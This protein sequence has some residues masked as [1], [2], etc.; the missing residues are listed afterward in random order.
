M[1]KS[2]TTQETAEPTD[3]AFKLAQLRQYQAL[4]LSAKI[5]LTE[6]RVREW[7]DAND[8]LVYVAFSGGKD[9]TVLL[10][11]V[12]SI[13]PD[14]PAVFADTG[15]ELNSILEFVK[16]YSD[17]V[18][19]VKPKM[20][21][22]EVVKKY[23]YPVVNKEQAQR[24]YEARTTKSKELLDIRLNGY[25]SGSGKIS[26]KWRF[27]IDAPFNVTSKCCK[28]LKCSPSN[29]YGKETGR[30]EM[31][32]VMAGESRLR[33]QT[34]IKHGCNAFD[35][36]SPAGRPMMF[37]GEQDVL[38]YL[39][40]NSIPFA[41]CYGLIEAQADGSLKCSGEQ[42]TGCKFCLFGAHKDAENRIQRLA[43]IEPESYRHAMEDLHYDKVMD[44]LGIEW[45]PLSDLDEQRELD[46]EG[47]E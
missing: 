28:I 16:T 2:T 25:P 47:G 5:R 29:I 17:K 34:Y 45:R 15:N 12:W 11:I 27:V 40:N 21:F 24:I 36:K 43:R 10:D 42:R 19:W 41:E 35:L 38:S 6:M 39:V 31:T 26:N 22:E 20:S 44:F 23:G 14:V 33:M 9:S 1:K 18:I 8:G 46:F 3:N 37:W 32:A 7:Y 30:R 4:P 13:Y